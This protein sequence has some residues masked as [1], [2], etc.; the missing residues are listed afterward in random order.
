MR[1]SV[2]LPTDRVDRRDDFLSASAVS[3]MARAMEAAGVDACH[4]TDH[5]FPP[6]EFVNSGGHH[7]LDPLVTLAVA[8]GATTN[9]LL[10][11]HVFIP[12][13]R[14]PF[15]AA[16]AVSTLAELSAGRVILG[17]A[18]GYLEGE[19]AACGADFRSR[20]KH[21]ESV[22]ET[23][24]QAWTGAPIEARGRRWEAHGNVMLPAPR[25]PI[26]IWI[27]G[28]SESALQRAARVGDG[29]CPFPASP[30]L[31]SVLRTRA[32]SSPEQ[33][34]AAIDMLREQSNV[35]G[36]NMQPVVCVTPFSH[37]HH[38]RDFDPG[39]LVEEAA[40]LQAIGVDWLSIRLPGDDRPS[41]LANVERL[42]REVV[43]KLR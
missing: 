13:Y 3:E 26:P 4:V 22:I 14:N 38:R 11:T 39:H 8:S 28:N 15:L 40:E 23:M 12:A 30:R 35:A 20:G 16:K 19:F 10:H 5:P 43:A 9:L 37:P 1:L 18:A 24:R 42:G 25:D 41:F 32:M 6:R 27:G 34:R 29:W 2:T 36:R 17:V 31:A 33:L 7:S 21:L